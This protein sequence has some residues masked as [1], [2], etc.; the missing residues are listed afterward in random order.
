MQIMT[1]CVDE[2]ELEAQKWMVKSFI[3]SGFDIRRHH[4][5]NAMTRVYGISKARA[6]ELHDYT[7]LEI[8]RCL[9]GATRPPKVGLA[10]LCGTRQRALAKYSK[11][12][13]GTEFDELIL[14]MRNLSSG[15]VSDVY[16]VL[17]GFPDAKPLFNG[18]SG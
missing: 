12:L 8:R 3:K 7:L 5:A 15:I 4:A 17:Y 2:K 1:I 10:D 14:L 18:V 13:S 9:I 16:H 6:R 11:V